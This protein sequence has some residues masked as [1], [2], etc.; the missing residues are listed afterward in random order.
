MATLGI[1]FDMDGVIIHNHVFHV[2]AWMEFCGKYGKPMTEEDYR[3]NINGRTAADIIKYIF[4]DATTPEL[5]KKY[6]DEKELLYRELYRPHLK[7]SE[8]LEA[9]LADAKEYNI[10]MAVAT[11]APTA[12]ADFTL[13][14]LKIRHY[15]KAV[16]D[17]NS[18]T[19]GKPDPQVY[20]KAADAIGVAPQNC[21][22][23][24][25]AIM[26]IRAG[27]AAGSYVVGV[28][29]SHKREELLEPDHIIEDFT[30]MDI[31][32]LKSLLFK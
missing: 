5:V 6:S 20:L 29:S 4:G 21:V 24:E 27:K 19:K 15:F 12:N 2:Q 22:V 30:Q 14:G 10:P 26:G 32:K 7:L 18:V 11:S 23:F 8:G 16:L 31:A 13:D 9:F 3:D 28:A 25:D 17:E 1:I